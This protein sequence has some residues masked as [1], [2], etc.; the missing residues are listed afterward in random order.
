M[1]QEAGLEAH[2]VFGLHADTNGTLWIGTVGD[3]LWRW[4]DGEWFHYTTQQGLPDDR[5]YSIADDGNGHLWLG[6][7]AG[8]FRVTRRSITELDTREGARLNCLS[9]DRSDGLPTRECSG[10]AQPSIQHSRDGRLLFAMAE[11]AVALSPDKL[12]INDVPPP[13]LVEEIRVDGKEFVS[14]NDSVMRLEPGRH[15]LEI[16]YTATSL[17]A[18]TKIRF[19]C[20]MVGVETEWHDAGSDRSATYSLASPGD[21]RFQVIACNNDGVWSETGATLGLQLPPYYWQRS[22]FK[23]GVS[24]A[25]L[26]GVAGAVWVL[27]RGRARRKHEELERQQLVEKERARIAR[28]I[29]D[30]LGASLTEI[31]LLSE[32]AQRE[33]APPGQVRDDIRRI[34]AKAQS[35][36]RA[37]DEI[38]WAVNPRNDTLDSFISYACAHAEEHLR[39]AGLR[40]R[41]DAPSPLPRH[42]LRADIRHHLF[43]AFKEALNNIVKHAR[44]SEVHIGARVLPEC[45]TLSVSDNGCGFIYNGNGA[46]P[47][48]GNGLANMKARLASA[49]GSF[50]CES[51]PGG[52]TTVRLMVPL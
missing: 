15:V 45:L 10:G 52:G 36:T 35:S 34:A 37:L 39:L 16:H 29:H 5:I 21:Y 14:N 12:Q 17:A 2:D 8:I 47:A 41:L 24:A 42:E 40:C 50:E 27:E 33:A 3:G 43:L 22:W 7:P 19:R 11:G 49:G 4:Q 28:D 48:G 44:A 18:P 25:S 6:S 23:G 51:K 20:R 46:D 13:I 30:E 38:V 1:G 9:F 31:G 26:L 32:F